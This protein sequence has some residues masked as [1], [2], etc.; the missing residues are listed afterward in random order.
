MS[1][2]F[3]NFMQEHKELLEQELKRYIE[4]LAAPDVLKEAMDYSLQA[5]G[6]RIRPLLVFSVIDALGKDTS[7]GL[8]AACS[9]EMIHTYSLIHDDLPG[10]DNDDLRRGKP[11][12]HIVFGEA[13]A[14]LAGDALLTLSFSALTGMK[15]KD[16]TPEQKLAIIDEIAQCA[17]AEGMI[18]GQTVDMASEGKTISLEDLEYIHEHKTGKLLSASI[19]TGAILA[20][21]NEKQLEALRKF[22]KHLGLAFQIRDDILDVE[23]NEELIGKRVGSDVGNNKSTYPSLLTLD[24]AKAKL[25]EEINQAIQALNSINFENS[26]LMDITRLV[27]ERNT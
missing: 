23:G 1:S 15:H 27:A 20:G 8:P 7:I 9:I 2:H 5:G 19:L 6:K 14:I 12:N 3:R 24:G 16:I 10:M 13:N 4:R 11:T 25:T 17:G 26:Y 21:A 18:G 22:S